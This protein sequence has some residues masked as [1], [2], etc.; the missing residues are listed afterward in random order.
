[1]FFRQASKKMRKKFSKAFWKALFLSS[2]E[3]KKISSHRS[4]VNWRVHGEREKKNWKI[5]HKLQERHFAYFPHNSREP[6]KID[7]FGSRNFFFFF[8]VKSPFSTAVRNKSKDK[9]LAT[10]NSCTFFVVVVVVVFP[11]KSK[12]KGLCWFEGKKNCH[13]NEWKK[14]KLRKNIVSWKFCCV[15]ISTLFQF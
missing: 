11:I 3:I 15:S 10:R 2:L 9:S 4:K 6:I 1:M 13:R 12:S 5:L 7:F 14:K 8:L